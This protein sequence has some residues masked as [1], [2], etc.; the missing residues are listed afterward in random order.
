MMQRLILL[1]LLLMHSPHMLYS[2]ESRLDSSVGYLIDGIN[3]FQY[4]DARLAFGMWMKELSADEGVKMRLKPYESSEKIFEDYST[5]QFFMLVVNPIFYLRNEQLIKESSQEYWAVQFNEKKLYKMLLLVNKRSDIKTLADLKDKRVATRDDNL[6]GRL[7]FDTELLR[8]VHEKAEEHVEEV[9]GV[10][11][12]STA[13]LKTF[14]G[15]VDACIV[16]EFAFKL[17]NEMNPALSKDLRVLSSSEQIFIP[18]LLAFHVDMDKSLPTIFK[19][20]VENIENSVRGRNILGLFKITGLS[21]VTDKELQPMRQY[22][23]EYQT[24]KQRY[25]NADE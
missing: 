23:S 15:D 14:F 20:N 3:D 18:M 2:A 12:S 17:A 4:K 1:S 11:K 24:L 8:T 22:Y 16:P 5:G 21:P 7:F 13:I 10:K 25:G 6:L 19:R 9:F